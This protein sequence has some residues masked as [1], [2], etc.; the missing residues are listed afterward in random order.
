VPRLAAT[1]V[2]EASRGSLLPRHKPSLHGLGPVARADSPSVAKGA[3]APAQPLVE[4][5]QRS[6]FSD[7]DN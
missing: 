4:V 6:I 7:R 3:G 1:E 2:A 5:A